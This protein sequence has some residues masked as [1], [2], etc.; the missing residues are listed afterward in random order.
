MTDNNNNNAGKVPNADSDSV[1]LRLP[2]AFVMLTK[3]GIYK[4][5][6]SEGS[7]RMKTGDNWT[8]LS[9]MSMKKMIDFCKVNKEV[10]NAQLK[11]ERDALQVQD[12]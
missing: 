1:S 4:G 6:P 11:R 10:F 9:Y 8:S 2:E 7:V 5:K 3:D 12:L